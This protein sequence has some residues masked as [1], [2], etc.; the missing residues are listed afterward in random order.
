MIDP[1]YYLTMNAQE[2]CNYISQE[3]I[4][5]HGGDYMD[6]TYIATLEYVQSL[7]LEEVENQINVLGDKLT[8]QN[9]TSHVDSADFDQLYDHLSDNED[10]LLL[11]MYIEV[12]VCQGIP[13]VAEL[14]DT[15]YEVYN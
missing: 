14:N 11:V 1:Y 2:L 12:V 3:V 9:A 7:T 8:M 4:N 6:N 5:N 10:A 15:P 13:E